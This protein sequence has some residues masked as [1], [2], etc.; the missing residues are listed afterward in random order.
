MPF[1]SVTTLNLS[2][3]DDATLERLQGELLPN[4]IKI[5]GDPARVPRWLKI[6]R[7]MVP[8]FLAKD[9]AESPVWEITGAEFS[10]AELHTAAGI[11]IRYR[12]GDR[13]YIFAIF[14]Y[15]RKQF[16]SSPSCLGSPG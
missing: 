16:L 11:S 3:H 1:F 2:G 4:M 10:R 5:K 9:P 7:G 15:F 14:R 6:N 12:S 13:A 8:D